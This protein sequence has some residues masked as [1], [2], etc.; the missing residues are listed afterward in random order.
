VTDHTVHLERALLDLREGPPERAL[1]ALEAASRTSI[2][3][4]F[5]F[6]E[7]LFYAGNV[8]SAFA[9]YQDIAKEPESPFAGAA[10]E[11]IYLIEEASPKTAL[12][13]FGRMAYEDW[14]GN[15]AASIAIADSLSRALSRG[16]LW[17]QATLALSHKLEA[18]GDVKG[19]LASTLA[20]ADSLPEDRL[21]P[22][23]RQRA[24]DLYLE[25]LKEETKALAQYEECLARY[26]R[27]W[28]AAEVR[29]RVE[30]LRREKRF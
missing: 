30:Q 10:L 19:A 17:A 6:A 23:A 18:A 4:A 27:A 2:E 16:P 14:R 15:A 21:A 29:R 7:A 26:P 22:L 9:R 12:P 28:N 20:I 3:A 13:A 11:R 24:G 8:D 25:R 5:R 1:P